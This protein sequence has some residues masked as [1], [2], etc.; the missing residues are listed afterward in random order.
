[1]VILH[2]TSERQKIATIG[3]ELD[4]SGA[5]IEELHVELLL[6]STDLL[7]QR[8][9]RDGEPFG[10]AAEVQLFSEHAEI[11]DHVDRDIHARILACD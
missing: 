1:M 8:G 10:G 6:K 7:T 4:L 5:P 3:S 11:T 9:R 2:A